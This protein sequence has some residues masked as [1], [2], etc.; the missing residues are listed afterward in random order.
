MRDERFEQLYR[1]NYEAILGYARRRTA[2]DEAA[3]VLAETFLVAWR[4]LEHVP[5]GE[6]ARLWLYATARRV[7]ANQ[8][9]ARRRRGR[10]D[11]RLRETAQDG[12]VASGNR[13]VL[14]AAFEGLSARDRELLSL[15]GW[16]GLDA[17][18]IGTVLGCSANAARIRLHRA[19][20]R[21]AAELE[22][23]GW[24]VNPHLL[25]EIA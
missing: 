19:R 24:S 20:R 23:A 22:R 11:A 12:S 14:A 10:L 18:Q 4:R 7:L 5:D 16:E 13:G 17:T 21:F 2:P 15:A 1:S 3:D 9:R 6:A 8:E 25:E